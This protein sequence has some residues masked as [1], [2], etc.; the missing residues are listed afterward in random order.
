MSLWHGDGFRLII[1]KSRRLGAGV[2]F[3]LSFN[4]LKGFPGGASDT[5]PPANEGDVS[6]VSSVQL[7]SR[8]QLF[9]T[10]WTAAC[11]ASLPSPTPGACSNSWPSSQCP[12]SPTL[13]L[14]YKES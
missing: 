11:Q 4:P 7:L 6:S 14:D 9:E 10:S 3:Y 5:N 13:Q 12:S 8:V 1:S 2:H